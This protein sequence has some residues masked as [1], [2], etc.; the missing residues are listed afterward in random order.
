MTTLTISTGVS[1]TLKSA[2][3]K[4]CRLLQKVANH[5][6]H[7]E[8]KYIVKIAIAIKNADA[9]LASILT[10]DQI[11]SAFES[12]SRPGRGSNGSN[13]IQITLD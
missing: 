9:L 3:S 5:S 6:L 8:P 11:K 12:E 7:S 13:K 1:T 10:D 2:Q 4:K